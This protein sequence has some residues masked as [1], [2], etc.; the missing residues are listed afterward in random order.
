MSP[1]LLLVARLHVLKHL[2]LV[3]PLPEGPL[4]LLTSVNALADAL[5]DVNVF[6]FALVIVPVGIAPVGVGD[7]PHLV[8][9]P[10]A[11][12][13]LVPDD[14]GIAL[15]APSLVRPAALDAFGI[16]PRTLH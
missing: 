1:P 2:R 9:V 16:A 14:M 12:D 15:S 4:P 6:F 3:H 11:G 8:E 5:D 7:D 10:V 13:A